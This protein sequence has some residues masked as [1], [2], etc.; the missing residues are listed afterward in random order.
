MQDAGL[1]T[2]S[3]VSS[4]RTFERA[5]LTVAFD[6]HPDLDEIQVVLRLNLD[7]LEELSTHLRGELQAVGEAWMAVGMADAEA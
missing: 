1:P 7:D 2:L 6:K 3:S 5:R 4:T